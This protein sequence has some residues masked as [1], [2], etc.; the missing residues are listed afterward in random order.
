MSI[1]IRIAD[2]ELKNYLRELSRR[3]GSLK[4]VMALIGEIVN[5]SIQTNF[6]VGG[7]PEWA[8]LS[9]VTIAN[10]KKLN[11]WPGQILVRSGVRGGLMGSVSYKPMDDKVVIGT[12][13]VYAKVHQFGAKKG[14]FGQKTVH[15]PAHERSGKGTK[16]HKVRA[17]TRT[18]NIPWGDIPARPFLMIQDND[19]IKIK[20]KLENYIFKGTSK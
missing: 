5:E 14:Q 9:P 18:M 15:I 19:W 6:E 12:N 17:H 4:P 1:E 16:R 11:K 10:R 3:M 13:K 8:P 7:R 20:T 2:D